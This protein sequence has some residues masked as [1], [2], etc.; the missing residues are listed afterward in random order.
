MCSRGDDE[1]DD[2]LAP[3]RVV[4]SDN[5]GLGDA[6]VGHQHLLDFAGRTFSPA[7]MMR[8]FFRPVMW[9]KP[10]RVEPAEVAGLEITVGGQAAAVS[11]GRLW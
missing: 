9:R 4:L 11:A 6:G 1:S 2:G 10:S 8:S 5:G 3:R 7:T